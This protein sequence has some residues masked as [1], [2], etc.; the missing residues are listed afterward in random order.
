MTL[1]RL[2]QI[3]LALV[4][5]LGTLL[6]GSAQGSFALPVLAVVSA[7]AAIYWTDIRG[8]VRL[9]GALANL[10]ALVAVAISVSE[11]VQA[12][13]TQ[14]LVAIANLLIYLQTILLF[15]EKTVRVGWQLLSLS[16]L[17]VVVAAAIGESIFFGVLVTLY[18]L[19]GLSAVAL[20]CCYGESLAHGGPFRSAQVRRKLGPV[21]FSEDAPNRGPGAATQ[22][23]V[24]P[25][26]YFY[27]S[28]ARV[29]GTLALGSVGVAGLLFVAAP[30]YGDAKLMTQN[31]ERNVGI[32]GF[33]DQVDLNSSGRRIFENNE[34][35][36]RMKLVDDATGE[37]FSYHREVYLRGGVAYD[38]DAGNWKRPRNGDGGDTDQERFQEMPGVIRQQIE[39]E[40]MR[41]D[42]LFSVYPVVTT[43]YDKRIETEPLRRPSFNSRMELAI[44]TT[45]F[46]RGEQHAATPNY[47]PSWLL[48]KAQK[49]PT[50]EKPV[51]SKV[52]ADESP[53]GDTGS[54]DAAEHAEANEDAEANSSSTRFSGLTAWARE[55]IASA[56]VEPSDR[57]AVV[58]TLEQQLRLSG[59]FAYSLAMPER[60][61]G[62][63][64]IEDFVTKHR[65]GNCEFFASAL[66]LM[67]RSQN[68]P[69]RMVMGYRSG[70][71][72]PLGGYLQ[73]RQLH[74]HA[75]A[76]AYLAPN[77]VPEDMKL[78]GH[79]YSRGAWLRL[80]PTPG[81]EGFATTDGNF[82][83]WARMKNLFDHVDLLWRNYVIG[84]DR[85]RQERLVYA[86]LEE[87]GNLARDAT[88]F[89]VAVLS[90]ILGAIL[91]TLGWFGI[92]VSAVVIWL[93]A[94]AIARRWPHVARPPWLARLGGWWKLPR[95]RRR[96]AKPS[97]PR[98][99][100][101]D[102]FE[103]IVARA[104]FERMPH[105]T[106]LEFA[107]NVG[108][109]LFDMPSGRVAAR[110]PRQVV[111]AFYRVRYG[112]KSLAD[113][114][115]AAVEMA[116][117]E[118]EH[119]LGGA[120]ASGI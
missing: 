39:I 21:F 75:W 83:F 33:A 111:E 18:L 70:D 118:L 116:L 24:E 49:L 109:Q 84:F 91:E 23:V 48:E 57:I 26:R 12:E 71:W 82:G 7:A 108:G 95:W 90:R 43:Y 59:E 98:V 51:S 89:G 10:A 79:D 47:M 80:D 105:Q 77:Q 119:V 85:E 16:L 120:T 42:R 62:M 46:Y 93:V 78:P 69:A 87:I 20:V 103:R 53:S 104:G 28:L 50:D 54:T 66:V 68:I 100:F 96:A 92:A 17:Q 8:A 9:N 81:D 74:A 38:Y 67:L 117:V 27:G 45:G 72:N 36:M 4:A 6:L 60:T 30:R 22:G 29:L 101:Y 88:V 40:A 5:V 107:Q 32:T 115:A 110:A 56:D 19:C 76:E 112:G 2:T 113:E 106:P 35:V 102:R 14:Q 3:N 37:P 31:V 34:I 61:P 114:E 94:K 52:D 1:H 64:P 13:A 44:G 15:Q 65:Q 25:P 58:R 11:V 97:V 41:H 55:A 63:D 73:V 86:P 99:A